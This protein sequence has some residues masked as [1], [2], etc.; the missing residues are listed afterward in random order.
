MRNVLIMNNWLT[1]LLGGTR[2]LD[3]IEIFD[4]LGQVEH[5]GLSCP[6][7]CASGSHA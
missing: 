5:L 2:I 6:S 3:V 7:F 4:Q 1:S